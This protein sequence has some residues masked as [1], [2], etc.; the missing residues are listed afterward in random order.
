MPNNTISVQMDLRLT[1]FFK[2]LP[3]LEQPDQLLYDELWA[4]RSYAP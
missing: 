3:T 2:F 4:S 1:Y